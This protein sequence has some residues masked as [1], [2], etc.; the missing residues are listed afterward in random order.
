MVSD[1]NEWFLSANKCDYSTQRHRHPTGELHTSRY[2]VLSAGKLQITN[3]LSL[4]PNHFG[5]HYFTIK[6]Q[7][8]A[9]KTKFNCNNG[10]E[11]ASLTGVFNCSLGTCA[12]PMR[13]NFMMIECVWSWYNIIHFV[14]LVSICRTL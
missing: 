11:C 7:P 12:A 6:V 2:N 10:T 5:E 14:C 1:E 13:M 3:K 4:A 9:S 8:N